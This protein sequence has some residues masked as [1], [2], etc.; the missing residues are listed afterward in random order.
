MLETYPEYRVVEQY[1]QLDFDIVDN[2]IEYGGY[3]LED[4][5]EYRNEVKTRILEERQREEERLRQMEE[6]KRQEELQQKMLFQLESVKS[7]VRYMQQQQSEFA[8]QQLSYAQSQAYVNE[9]INRKLGQMRDAQS[10]SNA[11]GEAMY[12]KY[13]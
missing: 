4:I 3:Y 13:H 6:A 5:E 9:S 11:Y 12:N 2:A 1:D 10:I 8:R 7:E